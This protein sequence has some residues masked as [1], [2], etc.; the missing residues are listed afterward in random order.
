[1]S[2]KRRTHGLPFTHLV[3]IHAGGSDPSTGV[4][5]TR[6]R[7]AITTQTVVP[8]GDGTAHQA[9]LQSGAVGNTVSFTV[10][11]D[12]FPSNDEIWIGDLPL[13]EGSHFNGVN[14]D[15]N[16][17]AA[18]LSNAINNLYGYLGWA[19]GAVGNVV[20]VSARPRDPQIRK[21]R[22]VNRLNPANFLAGSP[23]SQPDDV[24][25]GEPTIIS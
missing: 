3:P 18:N 20:T 19:A 11:S 15:A 25:F 10:A 14:G 22:V 6:V 21:I 17:T 7:Q 9:L 23:E 2:N 24:F 1:M 8:E 4:N 13:I 5:P 16:G 12:V